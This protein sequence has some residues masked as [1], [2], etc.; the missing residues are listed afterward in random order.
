AGAGAADGLVF[1]VQPVSTTAVAAIAPAVQVT[2]QDGLGNTVTSF[3]GTVT[4][5][6]GNN[7]VAGT[8]TGTTTMAATNGVA[9]FASLSID[10]AGSGYTLRAAARGVTNGSRAA[11][12]ITPRTAAT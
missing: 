5:A 2:A 6:L 11:L 4:V 3:T 9:S 1:T 12:N 7:P 8:L 10:R